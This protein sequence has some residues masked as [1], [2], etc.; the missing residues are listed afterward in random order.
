M[1]SEHSED[2]TKGPRHLNR[3]FSMGEQNNQFRLR[4]RVIGSRQIQI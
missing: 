1:A 4:R 2:S 3:V